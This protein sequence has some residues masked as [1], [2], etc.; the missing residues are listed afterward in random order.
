MVARPPEELTVG[1]RKGGFIPPVYDV[2]G[3]CD[4]VVRHD[5]NDTAAVPATRGLPED[6]QRWT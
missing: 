6:Y 3:A 5:S 1:G 4:R 2:Y